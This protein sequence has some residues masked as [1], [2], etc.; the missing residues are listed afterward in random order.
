MFGHGRVLPPESRTLKGAYEV[1]RLLLIKAARRMRR[2]GYY[3][4]GLWLWLSI[5]DGTWSGKRTLPAVYDDKALLD[6]LEAAM[7]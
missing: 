2:S 7:E 5:K 4:S 1:C 3:C 6:A